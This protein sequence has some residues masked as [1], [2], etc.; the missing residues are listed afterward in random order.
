[1]AI[2]HPEGYRESFAT[3]YADFAE[4]I[5]GSKLGRENKP[6]SEIYPKIT[7]GVQGVSFIQATVDSSGKNG[8]WVKLDCT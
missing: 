4:S 8:A 7:D 1:M 5:I 3:L 6:S 2:G